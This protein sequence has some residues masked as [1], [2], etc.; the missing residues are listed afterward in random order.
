ME[1]K[2]KKRRKKKPTAVNVA[3]TNPGNVLQQARPAASPGSPDLALKQALA[4]F[5]PDERAAVESFDSW[6]WGIRKWVLLVI[7]SLGAGAVIGIVLRRIFRA[8]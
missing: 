5:T 3:P 1:P 2:K 8:K 4:K 6:S 7:A